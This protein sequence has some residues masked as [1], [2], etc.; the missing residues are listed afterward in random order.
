MIRNPQT[1]LFCGVPGV[2]KT[3]I[4][5]SVAEKHSLPT[6]HFGSVLFELI[7]RDYPQVA[8]IDDIRRELNYRDYDSLQTQAAMQIAASSNGHKI[9]ISHL[10]IATTTGFIPGFPKKITK[11]L[12]PTVVFIIEAP[13]K[14]IATRRQEDTSR[15]RGH[16]LE[17]QIDFHQ[18]HNRALAAAYSFINGHAVYP[19]HN[20][21]GK[22]DQAIDQAGN[23]I[24]SLI[25]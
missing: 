7:K 21:Q 6:F 2:G 17:D 1:F 13:A 23:I 5:N 25:K 18:N 22:I 19:I 16:Y 3:S 8:K 20:E 4:V 24:A 11:I 12:R 14:E 9:V 10:S 15:Q